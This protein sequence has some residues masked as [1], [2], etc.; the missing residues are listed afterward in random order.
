MMRVVRDLLLLHGFTQTSA[1]WT[2]VAA[3]VAE[4]YRLHAPD[5]RG[6]GT[7]SDVRP[8]GFDEVVADVLGLVDGPF[9]L[10]GYSMGGRIAQLVALADPARVERLVLISTSP[11]L[12]DPADRAA[13][14]ESD[15]Q[16]ATVTE[17][18]TIEGFAARWAA[19]PL[20]ADQP[21]EVA[22]LAQEDRLRNTPA[23]LAAA[24]RGL[25]TGA[26]P[27]LW[28]RLGD[29]RMPVDLVVGARDYKFRAINAV[30]TDCIADA[31][32][33]VVSGAGH[34]VH[35]ERPADVAG[36]ILRR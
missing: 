8:I 6:H 20:F 2:P 28:E 31:A 30:M 36:V 26:M 1:T 27:S 24:L 5:L 35:L 19:L 11:G 18:L 33:H 21:V 9:T 7:A 10:A 34:A 13:R 4:R 17:A 14:L 3:E 16:L 22:E 25:S 23:G 32:M 15:E 12:A 29:L